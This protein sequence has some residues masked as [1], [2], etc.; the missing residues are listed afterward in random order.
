M[1]S[2]SQNPQLSI[3]IQEERHSASHQMISEETKLR[4]ENIRLQK[5]LLLER[6]RREALSRQLSESE[7]SL[8]MDDETRINMDTPG[9]SFMSG[10][11]P[12][13]TGPST[14]G[15]IR[16]RTVSSPTPYAGPR[17]ISPGLGAMATSSGQC[18]APFTPPSPL[19]RTIASHHQ[20]APKG[21]GNKFIKPSPPPS[22]KPK[23]MNEGN[24]GF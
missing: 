6:E 20:Q 1:V 21:S 7:S 13:T 10:V 2:Q 16:P 22:P 24:G 14:S 4:E 3:S 19:G 17:P 8:E 15:A 11:V 23:Q 5:Q 9:A 12:M 18:S